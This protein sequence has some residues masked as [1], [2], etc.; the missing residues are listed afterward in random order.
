MLTGRGREGAGRTSALYDNILLFIIQLSRPRDLRILASAHQL[1][2]RMK[3][4]LLA[5]CWAAF[6]DQKVEPILLNTGLSYTKSSRGW[7]SKAIPLPGAMQAFSAQA[8][9]GV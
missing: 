6:L 4:S 8:K 5:F 7:I 1:I 2:I 9:A 3:D